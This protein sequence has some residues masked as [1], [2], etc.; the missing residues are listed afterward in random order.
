[1]TQLKNPPDSPLIEAVGAKGNCPSFTSRNRNPQMSVLF[2]LRA[3]Y[4]NKHLWRIL[5]IVSALI[6]A[7][8]TVLGKLGHDWWTDE[9]YST[10]C[11]FRSSSLSFFGTNANGLPALSSAPQR[12]GDWLRC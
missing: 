7:Y 6:F 11:S 9:N 8:A 1:L 3:G 2:N 4:S 10:A 5:A 12:F